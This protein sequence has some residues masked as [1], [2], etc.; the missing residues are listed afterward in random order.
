MHPNLPN[1]S[2]SLGIGI[3]RTKTLDQ[4]NH[5]GNW[6]TAQHQFDQDDWINEIIARVLGVNPVA[7]SV[8]H[9]RETVS[10]VQ[11]AQDW[12]AEEQLFEKIGCAD[13]AVDTKSFHPMEKSSATSQI[14]NIFVSPAAQAGF[15]V[16]NL[17][18]F[19]LWA[20]GDMMSN[21]ASTRNSSK[22]GGFSPNGTKG[23]Q[24]KMNV[25]WFSPTLGK[26]KSKDVQ[27][28]FFIYEHRGP[29]TSHFI[30]SILG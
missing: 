27:L 8:K 17:N 22:H 25:D 21:T 10:N 29:H 26:A 14:M 3:G 16:A 24:A 7:I 15:S 23:V 2:V 18:D 5:N 13:V 4:L 19:H 9:V 11:S 20:V 30:N 12:Q 1:A 6:N 28:D